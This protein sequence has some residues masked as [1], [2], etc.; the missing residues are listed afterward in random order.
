MDFS[1]G[2]IETNYVKPFKLRP[3]V[4]EVL[5]ELLLWLIL[6]SFSPSLL[7]KVIVFDA[8]RISGD[9]VSIFVSSC[10]SLLLFFSLNR[11]K[12]EYAEV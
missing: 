5:N 3:A 4:Q 7:V 8:D 11:S 1:R 12:S 6:G 10:I 9:T 2:L